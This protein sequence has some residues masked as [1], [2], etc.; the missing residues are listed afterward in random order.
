MPS[1]RVG[2]S[3]DCTNPSYPICYGFNNQAYT[4]GSQE[5]GYCGAK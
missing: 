5:Y 4:L 3:A 2:T 1:C